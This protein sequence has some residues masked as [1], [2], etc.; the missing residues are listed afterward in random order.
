VLDLLT[1]LVDKSLVVYEERDRESRYRLLEP[2][3]SMPET[4]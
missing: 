2:S 4:G 1:A 3:A